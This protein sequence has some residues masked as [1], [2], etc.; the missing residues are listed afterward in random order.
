M[1]SC[2]GLLEQ[3][4]PLRAFALLIGLVGLNG[5]APAA[6]VAILQNGPLVQVIDAD[7]G[8]DHT[9]I[10][11]QFYCSVRYVSNA[12]QN[13]G[14]ST[15]ITLRHGAGLRR[16]ALF[17]AAGIA[18]GR[19]RRSLRDRGASRIDRARR[20]DPRTDLGPGSGLRDGADRQRVRPARAA[21]RHEPAQSDC[22]RLR[23]R[24]ARGLR[25]QSRILVEQVRPRS[26]RGGRRQP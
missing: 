3:A 1:R 8:E 23:S 18:A 11:I 19:R 25:R 9:D 26:R 14:S 4:P 13:H 20:S 12:P 10:T 24:G 16:A 22:L 15:R 7:E 5:N 17:A 21:D 2:V 6:S